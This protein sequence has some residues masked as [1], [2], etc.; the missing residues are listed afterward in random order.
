[1]GNK[2]VQR[3]QP[4]T[5]SV[6][7]FPGHLSR[8]H[9]AFLLVNLFP[10]ASAT[11]LGENY[12]HP[13]SWSGAVCIFSGIEESSL[14]TGR[15]CTVGNLPRGHVDIR[16]ASPLVLLICGRDTIHASR[17]LSRMPRLRAIRH[18]P[19][20][21]RGPPEN[22]SH[23]AQTPSQIHQSQALRRVRWERAR[24]GDH[25]IIAVVRHRAR[26]QGL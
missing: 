17:D 9:W 12:T 25:D 21:A 6:G 4:V 23:I 7:T 19:R 24:H 26:R 14:P 11:T 2:Q 5:P 18:A 3:Q 20:G 16:P 22:V 13:K 15:V 1:M 8:G 10:V